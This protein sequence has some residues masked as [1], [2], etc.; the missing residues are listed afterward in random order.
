[1]NKQN[2]CN[3]G[4][5]LII[6]AILFISGSILAQQQQDR[7]QPPKPLST[8]EVNKMVDDLSVKLS[9]DKTQKQKVSE[10]FSAHFNKLRESM[11]NKQGKGSQEE[12]QQKRKD[13][14]KHVK[15]L[16][17]DEQKAEFD[18]FMQSRGPQPNQQPKR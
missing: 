5:L 14:E 3:T 15:N 8:T 7:N 17:N 4:I 16:L 12:M 18:N 9:L 6:G 2:R 13:F 11:G 10:L 1:M